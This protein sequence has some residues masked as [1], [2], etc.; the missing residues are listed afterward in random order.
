M[1]ARHRVALLAAVAA[2][3]ASAAC[4]KV[5]LL[6][7]SGSTIT[8]TSAATALPLNGTTTIIAQVI[9]PSGTPPHSGTSVT[10]TT[11]LGTIQPSQA[12]TDVNG[13]AVVTFKAGTQS[14]TANIS[15]ISGG[16]ASGTTSAVKIA[17]GAAA[18]G[19]VNVTASPSAV[20][21]IGG[22]STI[23]AS[24]LDING[25]PLTG[26]P[27]S[28]ST[29]AGSLTSTLV[30]TDAN[31]T[32]ST[33][34]TTTV[35]ATVTASVGA[36]GSTTSPGTGTGTGTGTGGGTTTPA[37]TAGQASGSVTVTVLNAPTLVITPPT[38]A[39]SA[40]LPS[41]F[42][43]AVT[44]ASQNG[45]AIRD[46]TVSWGDGTTQDLGAVT[47]NA[48]VSHVYA[49]QGTYTV[50]ATLTDAAGNPQIVSTSVS[51]VATALPTVSIT[52][53]TVPQVHAAQMPVTFQ[54]QVTA[55]T[56]VTIQSVVINWGD[57]TSSTLSGVN[58]TL[59]VQHT[60]TAAGSFTVTAT[61]TDS[62]GRTPF[63]TTTVTLP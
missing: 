51:V 46:L 36:Q 35:Q 52:P 12:T 45:S 39:P 41:S 44:A 61:A 19:R 5:P 9:E 1:I 38:T 22:Q 21:A 24:V 15:A 28:F 18:V 23:M 53:T 50:T 14:G 47:G 37:P 43:F 13:Q 33:I 17:I 4:Q 27:V 29:S 34:L 30:T 63:G 57:G 3:L 32:A 60:Y 6:A 62:L 54:L 42:T 8:L 10:F 31:A 16:A 7:P 26:A 49:V 25:N 48:V 11:T 40:G 56:G 58:G 20:P 59:S 2:I 55:P